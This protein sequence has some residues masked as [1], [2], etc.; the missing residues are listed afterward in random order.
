MG[1][2]PNGIDS[3]AKQIVP[4]SHWPEMRIL[5]LVVNDSQKK[6]SS[7]VGMRRGME[8]SELLKYRVKH[9]V[10]ERTNR[11]QQA[12]IQ[13]DFKTFAELTMTDSNQMHA[14][15]LDTHPPCVY[16]N[17]VSH[18]VVSLIHAYND[19]VNDIKV[20]VMKYTCLLEASGFV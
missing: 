12:I 19:A 13:K 1:T 6:V 3:I 15:C 4:A 2:K 8:T 14:C 17:D 9:I 20:L 18:A 5:V 7:A 10:P 11:M 16:M